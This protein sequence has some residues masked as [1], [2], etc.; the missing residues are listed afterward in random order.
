MFVEIALGDA[1]GCGFEFAKPEI[2]SIRKNDLSEYYPHNLPGHLPPG[3]FSDDTQMSCAIA[4]ALLE[5]DRWTPESLA[6]RFVI[7]YKRDPRNGYS[8]AL[9]GILD[10]VTSGKELLATLI[11][12]SNK[13]GAAMRSC[14]LGTIK[15][16]NEMLRKA[17]I[18]AKITHDTP[19]GIFS[20]CAIALATHYFFHKNGTKD[21]LWEYLKNH[22]FPENMP[23]VWTEMWPDKTNVT[24]DAIPCIKAAISAV[25]KSNSFSECLMRCIDYTG[26]VDSVSAMALGIASVIPNENEMKS[27]FPEHLISGLENG[28]YGFNYLRNLDR[29]LLEKSRF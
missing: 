3:S 10:S 27:D 7:C 11:P 21:G 22:P 25:V 15:D 24:S 13:C 16:E 20:S 4:E 28:K 6:E 23:E 1:Y 17:R 29:L 12:T 19:E 14:P 8:R 18:Q 26:D 5:Y 2:L 9:Q